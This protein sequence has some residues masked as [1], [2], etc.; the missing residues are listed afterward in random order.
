[1]G[2]QAFWRRQAAKNYFILD[3]FG[4]FNYQY[5][6]I[7]RNEFANQYKK[8]NHQNTVVNGNCGSREGSLGSI[9]PKENRGFFFARKRYRAS[10]IIE[11]PELS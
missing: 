3:I 9:T 2:S 1:M 8:L 6:L 7:L 4:L 5:S 11:E 10:M